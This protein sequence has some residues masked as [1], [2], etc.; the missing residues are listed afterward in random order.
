MRQRRLISL[1]LVLIFLVNA[2]PA[3]A[4]DGAQAAIAPSHRL[5]V[6]QLGHIY[7]TWNNCGGATIT[8]GLSYY[9]MPAGDQ[10]DQFRARDYLKPD[11]ADQNVS[12][13]QMVDFVNLVMA[14]ELNVSALVRRGGD[15][16]TI[17]R[18]LMADFPVVVEE[19]FLPP[20]E[21]WM[22]HYLLLIGY[23][24]AQQSYLTYDSYLGH[25]NFEGRPK[26][27]AELDEYWRHFNNVFIVLYPPER[28]AEVQAILGDLWDEQVGWQR[29]MERAQQEAAANPSDPWAWFNLGEAAT[30]L[31]Q[32]DVATI[33][34]RQA[35]DT[36]QVPWRALWYLHGVFE[37]FYQTGQYD[38]V[39][40]MA[41]NLQNITPYIE[42]ANYYRGLA[43]AA[44]GNTEQAIFRLNLVLEF[45]PNFY[46][47]ADARALIE[48]GN[49]VAP[50]APGT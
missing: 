30:A 39:I 5:D 10:A 18:L 9:G 49:F 24:E 43:Y 23:D 4:Q 33:A 47:A 8:M 41:I 32:Y 6:S 17:K 22:G 35:F 25:G 34:F 11:N 2:V 19:G 7:Q 14:R 20:E 15:Q 38:T 40:E 1:V 12:P 3:L 28:E 36:Q 42:E 13:W 31:G 37:A 45:N 21:D 16:D 26:P 27:Y 46:P 50:V 48:T 44:Q 29:S